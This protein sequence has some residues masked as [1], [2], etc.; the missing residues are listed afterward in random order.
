[1]TTFFSVV[2]LICSIAL[3]VSV[4]LQDEQQ[5]GLGT[6]SGEGDSLFGGAKTKSKDALLNRVTAVSGAGFMVSALMLTI[7]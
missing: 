6:L 1:M 5:G 4:L 2:F 7:F 3:I